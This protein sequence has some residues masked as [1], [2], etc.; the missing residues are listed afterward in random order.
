MEK[1]RTVHRVTGVIVMIFLVYLSITGLIIQAIDLR[2]VFLHRPQIDPDIIN[3]L[4]RQGGEFK[5]VTAA[6]KTAQ[7]LPAALDINAAL[8]RVVKSARI[9]LGDAPLRFVEIRMLDGNLVGSIQ[10]AQLNASFDGGTGALLGQS[11]VAPLPAVTSIDRFRY[12]VKEFHRMTIYGSWALWINMVV[13]LSLFLIVVSGIT[14]YLRMWSE[15]RRQGRA[16][17]IWVG[18]EGKQD[19]WKRAVHRWVGLTAAAFFLVIAFSG[20]WLAY[21]SL[22]FGYRMQHA[23]QQRRAMSANGGGQSAARPAGAGQNEMGP[24]GQGGNRSSQPQLLKDADIP[25]L[26]SVTLNS[27]RQAAN[28]APIKAV[29]IRAFDNAPQGV[30]IAGDGRDTRQFSFDAKTGH[31][32]IN[33]PMAGNANFPWGWDAHQLGKSIHRGSYFGTWARFVDFFAG[34]ALLYL[35]INGLALYIDYRKERWRT[36]KAEMVVK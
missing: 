11:P 23:M 20:E 33:D 28:G 18:G 36:K 4:E 6:D 29:R 17:F 21:E 7:A 16:S 19:D 1:L 15:R 13:G 27:E 30:V 31:P 3:V 22:V 2:L 24:S 8:Q 10:T 14:L 25:A 26:L 35:S 9:A 12:K 5:I 34:L 32:V